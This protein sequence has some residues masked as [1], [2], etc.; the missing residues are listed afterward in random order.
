MTARKGSSIQLLNRLLSA[1]NVPWRAVLTVSKL[2]IA[3]SATVRFKHA[4]SALLVLGYLLTREE[5]TVKLV[6]TNCAHDA[7]RLSVLSAFQVRI[8]KTM[9]RAGVAIKSV[10]SAI[11]LVAPLVRMATQRCKMT[12]AF[13]IK[14]STGPITMLITSVHA[15]LITS[16]MITDASVALTWSLTVPRASYLI[17]T[18]QELSRSAIAL[19]VPTS[20]SKSPS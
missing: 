16:L 12:S 19:Q 13:V 15:S 20:L 10:V 5:V 7:T 2:T 6:L 4:M 3:S 11:N 9:G 17:A 14:H 1:K 8:S 18:S